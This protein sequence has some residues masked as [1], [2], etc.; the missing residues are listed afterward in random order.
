MYSCQENKS[1]VLLSLFLRRGIFWTNKN[2]EIQIKNSNFT[3]DNLKNVGILQFDNLKN[4][5]NWL[6]DNRKNVILI[7]ETQ[8]LQ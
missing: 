4:V 2:L 5:R 8:D 6:F 1:S 7:Y 3:L